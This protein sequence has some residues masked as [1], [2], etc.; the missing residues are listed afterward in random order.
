MA[1][2]NAQTVADRWAAGA[3]QGGQRYAD[4]VASTDV[5][6]VGRAI[7]A[8]GALLSNFANAVQSGLWERRLAATGNQGWKNAVA[9]KGAANYS[10]GVAAAKNKYQQKMTAVL[11]VEAGLQ[12]QIQSMPSGTP[13]ANDARMLAWAN[14]MRQAKANGAFG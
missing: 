10:T 3:G 9:A 6:V 5:D 11:Q 13:A 2:P 1:I 12:S 7:S 4:G 14:G 8:K